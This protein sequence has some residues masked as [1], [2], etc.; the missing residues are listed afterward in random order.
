MLHSNRHESWRNHHL[1]QGALALAA[2]QVEIERMAYMGVV[3]GASPA[4]KLAQVYQGEIEIFLRG[5]YKSGEP[6][7]ELGPS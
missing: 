4:V 6:G 2:G 7:P 1:L 5:Y 3:P